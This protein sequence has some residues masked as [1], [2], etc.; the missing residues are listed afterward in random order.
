MFNFFTK[1]N[2]NNKSPIVNNNQS[3]RENNNQSQRGNNNQSPIV[4]NNKS[5]RVNNNKSQRVNN[6]QSPIVNNNQSQR[7]NNNQSPIVNNSISQRDINIPHEISNKNKK[8][9]FFIGSKI[10]SEVIPELKR[11]QNF[12]RGKKF[13]LSD[14]FPRNYENGE[15]F[16]FVLKYIYLGYL[17]EDVLNDYMSYLNSFILAVANKFKPV[18]S[19]GQSVVVRNKDNAT[20]KISLRVK[21]EPKY[22]SE[23]IIPYLRK[24]GYESIFGASEGLGMPYID[25]LFFNKTEFPY[26]V[27][28]SKLD[29]V[30]LPKT[31]I[32]IDN[33]CLIKGDAVFR[34]KGKV[35][36]DEKMFYTVVN[37]K[38]YNLVGNM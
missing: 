36:K 22:L 16:N 18:T 13:K 26:K 27:L 21:D 5:Q 10:N 14:P 35:S 2:K 32:V 8:S 37:D 1:P 4:N 29:E 19:R 38:L 6:N 31:D 34:R 15:K 33:I 17:D 7:G 9:H 23:I 11:M 24:E 25:I 3:P 28:N 20:K 12:I 30:Y